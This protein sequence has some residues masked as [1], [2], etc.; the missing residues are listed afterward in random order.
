MKV[1]LTKNKDTWLEFLELPE[2]LKKSLKNDFKNLMGLAPTELGKVL[3]YDKDLGK[4]IEKQ[5]YRKFRS[6]L[7]VPKLDTTIKK[8][9]MFSGFKEQEIDNDVPKQFVPAVEYIKELDEKYNQLVVNWYEEGKQF[10]EMHSDCTAKMI[11]S[12]SVAVVTLTDVD[13]NYRTFN[14]EAKTLENVE[15]STLLISKLSVPL[16]NGQILIMG[17]KFQ[18]NFRHGIPQSS[19]EGSRIS[20]TFRQIK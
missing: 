13:H 10:I 8:S 3:V 16:Q 5:I 18:D 6:Y 11:E 19:A 2:D 14:V 9:Y 15:D 1:Y 7:N 12:H 17:G 20:L 4:H